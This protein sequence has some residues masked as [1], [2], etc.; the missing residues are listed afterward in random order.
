MTSQES[1]LILFEAFFFF[2]NHLF[3]YIYITSMCE[4]FPEAVVSCSSCNKCV[5]LGNV[6]LN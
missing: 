5:K 1:P 2:F 4:Y 3:N 6:K